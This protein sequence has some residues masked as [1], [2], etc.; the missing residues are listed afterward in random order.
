[1]NTIQ[2]YGITNY[3]MGFRA[4]GQGLKRYLKPQTGLLGLQPKKPVCSDDYIRDILDSCKDKEGKYHI[5][6]WRD[7]FES[8]KEAREALI[9]YRR[10][11]AH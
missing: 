7:T 9:D 6:T 8:E 5:P 2:N 4:K 11:I 1:M 10:L 3:Q